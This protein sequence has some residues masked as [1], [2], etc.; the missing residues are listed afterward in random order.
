MISLHNQE[1]QDR[2]HDEYIKEMQAAV[3]KQDEVVK[4]YTKDLA[5]ELNS[6][7]DNTVDMAGSRKMSLQKKKSNNRKTRQSNMN[8]WFMLVFEVT[9]CL[10]IAGLQVYFIKQMLSNKLII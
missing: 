9:A 8:G 2:E 3:A 6:I 10:G 4:K 7:L 1:D 5:L